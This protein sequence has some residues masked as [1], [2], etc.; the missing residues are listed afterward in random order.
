MRYGHDWGIGGAVCCHLW[1]GGL[2]NGAF[3]T[4]SHPIHFQF[5]LCVCVCH[6]RILDVL[7][8]ATT[9]KKC[10]KKKENDLAE[11]FRPESMRHDFD[12]ATTD[13]R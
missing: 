6:G 9:L 4:D 1:S 11:E 2:T 3:P 5:P 7:E 12:I 10:I 8:M 13:R